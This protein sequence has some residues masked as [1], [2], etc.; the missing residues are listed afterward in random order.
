[1]NEEK[2]IVICPNNECNSKIRIPVRATVIRFKCSNCGNS[3]FAQHGKIT[4]S[5]SPKEEEPNNAGSTGK[6]DD[7]KNDPVTDDSKSTR[8]KVSVWPVISAI[9]FL[10]CIY[11]FFQREDPEAL[12]K[13]KIM[14]RITNAF[15]QDLQHDT[16]SNFA[17]AERFMT[18]DTKI[19]F[20]L[21]IQSQLLLKDSASIKSTAR[22]IRSIEPLEYNVTRR[23][24]YKD[25]DDNTAFFNIE[26]LP[27]E[28]TFQLQVRRA[29]FL[30]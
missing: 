27:S 18:D 5:H 23:F 25:A 15:I 24:K 17:D 30:K 22:F 16:N 6:A 20:E 26:Y 11:L 2:T 13:K 21:F 3:Y 7:Q 12:R 28:D 1:M 14:D 9:L 4:Y 19:D 10:V 8:R 29:D